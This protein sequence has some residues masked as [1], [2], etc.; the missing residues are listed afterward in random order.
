MCVTLPSV[1]IA[2]EIQK[3]WTSIFEMGML[4]S[5]GI[6]HLSNMLARNI[7]K[8]TKLMQK[9]EAMLGL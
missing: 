3:Y 9:L 7:P 8:C 5:F 1:S 4:I 2:M 6:L